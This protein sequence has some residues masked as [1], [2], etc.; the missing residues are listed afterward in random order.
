MADQRT[1]FERMVAI[2]TE[3]PP[4]GKTQ[5]N[6]QQ[7]FMFRGH[8]DV[9]NALNPLLSKHGVFCVPDVV[10]RLTAQR[11][12]AKGSIM[13][14]VDLHVRFT[15]Y[16]EAGDSITASTWG[17]GTDMGDKAT[18]KAM[19]MAYKNVLN[20]AFAIST[21]EMRDPDADTSDH[22]R[23][24]PPDRRVDPETPVPKSYAELDALWGKADLDRAWLE[25]AVNVWKAQHDGSKQGAL[26]MLS[27]VYV[28]LWAEEP[29][30]P[31]GSFTTEQVQGQ[32]A[33]VLN[34]VVLAG[35]QQQVEGEEDIGFGT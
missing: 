25:Q 3:L 20:Q 7:G 11:T 16:G 4:I 27:T 1:I 14:E 30:S 8:D 33:K 34:G 10:Q 12:T 6:I 5:K 13:F 31:I 23:A 35:P 18:N 9:L 17:E 26:Q 19:T 21:A 22:S 29:Q 28:R 24:T 2:Q 32:F 15:F